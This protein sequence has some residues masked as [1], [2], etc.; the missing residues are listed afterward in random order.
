MF[1]QFCISAAS[2]PYLFS[3]QKF[4]ALLIY[5]TT[6][7]HSDVKGPLSATTLFLFTCE[8]LAVIFYSEPIETNKNHCESTQVN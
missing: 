8:N 6:Y 4:K 2:V 3:S 7:L 1:C 5:A